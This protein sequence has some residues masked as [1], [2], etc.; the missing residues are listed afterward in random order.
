MDEDIN[1]FDWTRD[2][3]NKPSLEAFCFAVCILFFCL[4]AIKFNFNSEKK[5]R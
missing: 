3:N 2:I 4:E 1:L 5:M